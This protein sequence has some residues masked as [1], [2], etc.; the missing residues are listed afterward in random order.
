VV[1]A[2]HDL[3][4]ALTF[5]GCVGFKSEH[6]PQLHHTQR[7]DQDCCLCKFTLS[8]RISCTRH[9]EILVWVFL[10]ETVCDMHV[11]QLLQTFSS[12]TANTQTSLSRGSN[13]QL[14]ET[15]I[16]QVI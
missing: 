3:L 10:C 1:A 13:F 15:V 8:A 7:D 2:T 12:L 9:K 4:G 11:S 16:T 5:V 14:V 6:G